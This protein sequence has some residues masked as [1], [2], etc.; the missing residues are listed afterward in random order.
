MFEQVVAALGFNPVVLVVTAIVLSI[1]WYLVKQILELR[2]VVPMNMVHSVQYSKKTVV[3]GRDKADGNVYYKW[4]SWL[5]WF[6]VAVSEVSESIFKIDLVKYEAYDNKRTP[7]LVDVTAFYRI[8]NPALAAQRSSDHKLLRDHLEQ[9]LKGVVR[10]I[11]AKHPLNSIMEDRSIFAEQFTNEVKSQVAEFGVIP[12]QSIEL[13][14]IQDAAGSKVIANLMAVE[15]AR[16]DAESRTAVAENERQAS[17]AETESKRDREIAVQEAARDVGIRTAER[18]KAVGIATE[19]SRQTVLEQGKV[20][21][22][23]ELEIQRTNDTTKAEIERTVATTNARRD[24]D[25]A[26][27][28][29]EGYKKTTIINAE[30]DREAAQREADANLYTKQRDA[31]GTR[32]LGEAVAAAEQAS[33][34]APVN[35]QIELA[36]EIGSNE[37]YQ[38]FLLTKEQIIVSRDVGIEMAKCLTSA[39]IRLVGGMGA[40]GTDPQ[41]GLSGIMDMFT[42]KGGLNLTGAL[43]ALAATNEGAELVKRITG[44]TTGNKTE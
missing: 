8:V 11:L 9:S 22:E 34:M 29:A 3:Y 7:F 39:D 40:S 38:K 17:I 2:V 6:G 30:A 35:S 37:G 12:V 5:P 19:Q 1:V 15:Q 14:D 10:S 18:E 28:Q 16:I 27:V 31:E 36:R 24:Q 33:L 41:A 25:V 20:T 43:T 4:P 26:I 42:P 44:A 23:R 21:K 13:M 32:T